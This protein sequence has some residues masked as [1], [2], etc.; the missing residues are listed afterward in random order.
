MLFLEVG[1]KLGQQKKELDA[2][3][4]TPSCRSGYAVDKF[5]Q[6]IGESVIVQQYPSSLCI[7]ILDLSLCSV[8]VLD[9]I[10]LLKW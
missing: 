6:R 1:L 8:N 7:S 5:G 2:G 4:V 3:A 9:D 10:M